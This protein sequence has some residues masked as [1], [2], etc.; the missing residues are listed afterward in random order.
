MFAIAG[1]D[2]KFVWA[3]AEIVTRAGADCVVVSASQVKKP[4]A[5]RYEWADNPASCN[6]YST[7]GVPA[8]PF[9]TDDWNP[10][11]SKPSPTGESRRRK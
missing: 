3:D 7:E 4:V 11:V 2:K 9:R 1:A 8:S 5:V 10:P 6:L